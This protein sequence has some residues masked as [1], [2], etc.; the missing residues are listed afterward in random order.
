MGIKACDENPVVLNARDD[1]LN[2]CR[3]LEL[4]LPCRDDHLVM[5]SRGATGVASGV[6]LL[7]KNGLD[8]PN[9][10]SSVVVAQA[11]G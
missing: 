10:A 7:D 3:A 11:V 1:S 5:A 4:V 6:N 9:A 2:K 8:G